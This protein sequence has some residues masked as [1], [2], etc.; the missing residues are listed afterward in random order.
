[1]DMDTKL[2]TKNE[3]A[4]GNLLSRETPVKSSRMST[5][6]NSR[7]LSL[8]GVTLV[9]GLTSSKAYSVQCVIERRNRRYSVNFESAIDS[10]STRL[11]PIYRIPI[12]G[13][14]SKRTPVLSDS[15]FLKAIP[16]NAST[17]NH[18]ARVKVSIPS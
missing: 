10:Q 8:H 11:P 18:T 5:F 4:D 13:N 14:S 3:L 1:M 16:K 15:S 17:G 6:L 2:K 12:L 9:C 7:C